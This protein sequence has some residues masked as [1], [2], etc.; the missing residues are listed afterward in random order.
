MPLALPA[1]VA[2]LR[3]LPMLAIVVGIQ[4]WELCAPLRSEPQACSRRQHVVPVS[5]LRIGRRHTK[6]ARP[7]PA[8]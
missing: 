1:I 6:D 5:S 3:N 4:V 2:A 8:R 7:Y